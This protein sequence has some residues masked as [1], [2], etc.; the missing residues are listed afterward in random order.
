[1]KK[2]FLGKL[3]SML[4]VVSMALTLLPVSA[5]A[6][7]GGWGSWGFDWSDLW[8]WG[9][10]DAQD[11]AQDDGLTADGAAAYAADSGEFLRIFHLDC[12]RKYFT[13][14][15]I[16]EIIDQLAANHYTH[17]ELAFGNDGLRFL[18]NDMSVTVG[19]KTYTSDAVTSAIKAGNTDY[20]NEGTAN[21]LT[22]DDMDSIY[23]HASDKGIKIIPMID[24]PG[25]TNVLVTAMQ[26]L[27]VSVDGFT[28][29]TNSQGITTKAFSVSNDETVAF[30]TELV[31]KYVDYFAGKS[32]YFNLG[33]D[34]CGY[35]G[36]DE[37]KYTKLANMLST[38]SDYI[39]KKGMTTLLFNDGFRT[40]GYLQSALKG[41]SSQITIC[42]WTY[43]G[44]TKPSDLAKDFKLINTHNKW[45]YVAGNEDGNWNGY[46][47]AISNLNGQY[48][49]CTA[50]DGASNENY[51]TSTG[52]MLG[53]W[54]D[55]PAKS[56]D[57]NN[58]YTYI[59]TLA[60]NNPD[61][62]KVS[63]TPVEPEAFTLTL[64]STTLK[65]GASTTVTANKAVKEW[66]SNSVAVGVVAN[67][68]DTTAQTATLTAFSEG[69][70]TI[71]A[72]ATDGDT[73]TVSV[74][75]TNAETDTKTDTIYVDPYGGTYTVTI[76]G[77]LR[78]EDCT[79]V[80]TSIATAKVTYKPASSAPQEVGDITNGSEYYISNGS[81]YLTL[82]KNYR[83]GVEISSTTTYSDALKWTVTAVSGGYQLS[84]AYSGST[85]YLNYSSRG[86]SLSVGTN[87]STWQ[88]DADK[89]FYCTVT[90]WNGTTTTYYYLYYATGRN[91]GW[92]LSNSTSSYGAP[93]AEGSATGTSTITFTGY[94]PGQQT[95][96]T[97]GGTLYTII[98]NKED[99][100]KAT[101]LHVQ[102]W[103]TNTSIEKDS[104]KTTASFGSRS[105]QYVTIKATDKLNTDKGVLLSE[106]V[107]QVVED[108]YEYDGTYW[109]TRSKSN[110]STDGP[111][112]FKLYKGTLL[113]TS[114]AQEVWGSDR[115][116]SG[117]DF[118]YI[119]YLE[120]KWWISNDQL[121]WTEI[122]DTDGGA[123]KSTYSQQI[124][125]YYLRQTD[126][127]KEVTTYVKDWGYRTATNPPQ[128]K[129]DGQV[130]LTIAVVYPDGTV[131]P[132]ESSMYADSTVIRNYKSSD[133]DL[134]LILPENNSNYNIKKITVTDGKRDKSDPALYWT[135]S[136]S[137]TWE[138]E[139]NEAGVQWYDEATV[140]DS[141][142]ST[143]PAV[144]GHENDITWNAKDTA[145]LVL[146]YLEAVEKEENLK[147]S[148]WNDADNC[149]IKSGQIS[150]SYT[151]GD[152]LPTYF[153]RLIQNSEVKAGT[154]TL[155]NGA[156][157]I[158]T[159]GVKQTI[160]KDI[161]TV[162]DID[163]KYRSGVYQYVGAEISS[164]GF[165][166]T[167]HYNLDS[168]KLEHTYILDFGLPLE[169][170]LS[171]LVNA[172]NVSEVDTVLVNGQDLSTTIVTTAHGK[173]SYSKET[174]K[175]TFQLEKP[176]DTQNALTGTFNIRYKGAIG[177]TSKDITIGI[178]PASN[179][180]YEENFLTAATTSN[181]AAWTQTIHNI[182]TPQQT[183]K[184]G[185]T[186]KYVFGYDDAYVGTEE[187]PVK[188][189]LGVW[190]VSGLVAGKGLSRALTTEF[191]GNGFDLIGDCGP[192]T[193]RVLLL[194]T[195]TATNKGKLLDIDTRYNDGKAQYGETTLHQ[196]PL[197]HVM[198]E[199]GTY[200]AAIYAGGKTAT[201]ASTQSGTSG[202]AAYSAAMPVVS[203][204]DDLYAVLAEN[205]LTMADVE[206][207]NLSA[208]D[209]IAVP[210][211]RRSAA[212]T[213]SAP[214]AYAATDTAT[215]QHAAG[216]HVEIDGFRVYRSTG[217]TNYPTAEQNV[218]YWNILDVVK[219]EI[220]AYR[221]GEGAESAS[222]SVEN[223]EKTGGPQNEIYLKAG[224][225]VAFKLTDNSIESVQ[226]S[227]RAVNGASNWNNKAI[228]SNTEMYYTLD[229]DNN[230]NF[231]INVPAETT[232][233]LAI[234]NVKLPSTVAADSIKSAN[235][236][237]A[238]ELLMSIR[239]AL[240]AAPVDPEPEQPAVFAPEYL[241]A[242]VSTIRFFRNKLV[243]LTVSASADVAKL[244]V[245]G[246]ELRPTNGWLVRM[247]WSDTYTYVLTDTVKK[248]DSK[249]YEIIAY[250]ASGLASAAKTVSAN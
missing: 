57:Y 18:L 206:Y 117:E 97:I 184:V 24:I 161:T 82:S 174:K 168:N 100:S 17:I 211:A 179:V 113:S 34:E 221:E 96:V 48:K 77:D 71:T 226:V 61:Y 235:E 107:P 183:Q 15:Q 152:V 144:Y 195:N 142:S 224:Q 225:S 188:G 26:T 244:T 13:V 154:I 147:L 165:T 149:E 38:L 236:I 229:R 70:A 187:N 215:V 196:V 143:A 167:L 92:R 56:V 177:T 192:D 129:G 193:G 121:K 203:Y 204:D 6:A 16:N 191:Y 93:Y 101:D 202:V 130:A 41:K 148:Y 21:E 19:D 220:V 138:K 243:T 85:Y 27:G 86:V 116:Y 242:S 109:S 98:V 139:K 155:D 49:D 185:A 241:D 246:R 68:L 182:T 83:G 50:V 9:E 156:Y 134:G 119:R 90:G 123:T 114:N 69:T 10:D 3:L 62:F 89:G 173:L 104:S 28:S 207:I 59:Q 218:T 171:D 146:I 127:T 214:A 248:N 67:V 209:S 51:H 135:P 115:F 23:Q 20:Y 247:G 157:V 80:D 230:G 181:G 197:A 36:F 160:N 91:S 190:S 212:A 227:L 232:G 95:T 37:A 66:K 141:S 74:T 175:I 158:N 172:D 169:I 170:P 8:N 194:L 84:T 164:D 112:T 231:V 60:N 210:A 178:L 208:A 106:C 44:Y 78:G 102:L 63:S 46:S 35:E 150:V 137:I 250:D 249:T 140:W 180:L 238:E 153:G 94:K 65:P 145:K 73:A 43:S 29:N 198:L 52:C 14:D 45:Y 75:V 22:V 234:G 219:G 53:F 205:G 5:M 103:I 108:C 55:N 47:W 76:E 4:L 189:Q 81:Q 2:K 186:D 133:F 105:A 122:T 233:M 12:G 245:N 120:G 30:V 223:Y 39:H 126:V 162:P 166:L 159:S 110:N 151:E 200:T 128:T 237:A 72:T 31:K 99:L 118:Q 58:L 176:F 228:S 88:Y 217:N 40:S 239:M 125:A 11:D 131:S 124:V 222:V 87:P 163:A 7:Y 33:A 136:D 216:T 64:G 25:H 1:M 32:E 42:Y 111:H 132:S 79:T 213:Y 240:N 199:E 54:C 201:T